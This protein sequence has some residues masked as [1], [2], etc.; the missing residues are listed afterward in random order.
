MKIVALVPIKLNSERLPGKNIKLFSNGKPLCSYIFETMLRV[1]HIDEVY[2]YCSDEAIKNYLPE[3]VRFKK[4]SEKLDQNTTKI[5]EVLLSFSKDV[6]ADYY[7]LSHA[8]APFIKSESV[9][10]GVLKVLSG[11]YDSAFSV[12]RMQSFLWQDNKPM[13]YQLHDIP[14]TQD[15]KPVYEE[16]CGLYIYSSELIQKKNRRIGE[17]PYLLEVS[18]VEGIDIDNFA[19]FELADALVKSNIV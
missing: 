16:T 14:R 13:N 7:V 2:V 1:K 18:D 4:R 6:P 19:D 15:L 9:D 10:K 3:G 5:N 17:K 8:T 11:E 12:K